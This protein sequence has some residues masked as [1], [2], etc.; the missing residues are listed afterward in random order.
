[1]EIM[2]RV[3][4]FGK[5]QRLTRKVLQIARAF[6]DRGNE[7]LWLN[8]NTINRWIGPKT[9]KYILKRIEKFNPDI[10]FIHSM[11]LPLP[12]LEKI[13]G[14][15]I[16]TVQY[17]HDTIYGDRYTELLPKVA[18]WGRQVDLFLINAKGLHNHLKSLGID[19]PIFIVEGCDIYDHKKRH[20]LLPIWKSEV[21]FIGAARPD[22]PRIPLIKKLNEIC[23]LKVY[24]KNWEQFGIK[25]ATKKV[26]SREYGLICGGAKIMLGIDAVTNVEGHWTNRLWLTLGCGGFHLAN[27]IQ[28]MEE[29]FVDREHLVLYRNEDECIDLVKEYLFKSEERERIAEKGYRLVHE[30]YTFH[31]FVDKVLALSDT[32]RK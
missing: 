7:T 32:I 28:G 18:Q 4:I 26:N 14:T 8:P 19:N 13:S 11:D 29:F 22:E 17:Y 2:P 31:H 25:P 9:E 21:A 15:R 20:P 3:M 23:D 16:K 5:S 24:G 30:H 6:E 12:I 1:M 10:I 27:Y